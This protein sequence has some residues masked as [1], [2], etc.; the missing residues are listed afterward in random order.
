M[1]AGASE[2]GG[3]AALRRF[4]V[5]G[6]G[7]V[8]AIAVTLARQVPRSRGRG[9]CRLRRRE[10]DRLPRIAMPAGREVDGAA[11]HGRAVGTAGRRRQTGRA[12][13]GARP[14]A[15]RFHRRVPGARDPDRRRDGRDGSPRACRT[16]SG[17]RA[18]LHEL[19][20]LPARRG[21]GP[22]TGRL[23]PARTLRLP[24]RDDSG[25]A[26]TATWWRAEAGCAS[27]A[28][29]S[30]A[31]RFA[32]RGRPCRVLPARP[33]LRDPLDRLCLRPVAR[34]RG[35]RRVPGAEGNRH[36]RAH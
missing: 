15:T 36:R 34:P 13:V 28:A 29:G 8:D 24:H 35:P 10:T 4:L 2:G 31:R 30:D 18:M 7:E 21:S 16:D 25:L 22:Q 3:L 6:S 12:V 32:R 19:E 26:S 20:Q 1:R 11:A 23:P 5:D 9:D 17:P 33:A 14:A 27:G